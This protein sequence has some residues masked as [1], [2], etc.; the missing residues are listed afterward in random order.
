M[1]EVTEI[2]LVGTFH[3]ELQQEI[4]TDKQL[5]IKELVNHLARFKPTKIAVEWEKNKQEELAENYAKHN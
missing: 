5:E 3:F 1:A 4:L 2:I